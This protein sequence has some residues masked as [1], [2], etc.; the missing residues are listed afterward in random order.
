[1]AEIRQRIL[2]QK[3]F[4]SIISCILAQLLHSGAIRT[5][6]GVDST[7]RQ[8]RAWETLPTTRSTALSFAYPHTLSP[9]IVNSNYVRGRARAPRCSLKLPPVIFVLGGPGSGKGTQCA[10]LEAE[11]G[12]K[13]VCVGDLLRREAEKDTELGRGVADT[14]REGG[15]V[16]GKVTMRLLRDT[17]ASQGTACKGV[18]I[19][20]F[21]RAMDQAL[22]FERLVTKCEFVI[23]FSCDEKELI[24]R[25]M[26][27]G[28]T[29][30]REDDNIEVVE[31][32]MRTY[33]RQTL[34]VVEYYRR[35]GLLREIDGARNPSDVYNATRALFEKAL[36]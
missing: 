21:P 34:P 10:R 3:P 1:M 24:L 6:L 28:K 17:L 15:I 30:G 26:R 13:Q 20:G 25:L 36:S 35:K 33:M 18:L 32:R 7:M 22:E 8:R 23:F 27:R 9:C 5:A 14:I 2:L 11:F 19:D 4:S 31:K 29:S 16:P 12:L